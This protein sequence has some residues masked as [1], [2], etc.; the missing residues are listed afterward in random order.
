MLSTVSLIDPT[1]LNPSFSGPDTS[2]MGRPA[3]IITRQD[4]QTSVD[5]FQVLLTNAKAYR[6]QMLA[7]SKAAANFGYALEK[8]AHS[9]A[10]V[11]DPS[12]VCSSLQAAAGLHY[13]MSN[14]HQILSDTVYKQFEIPLLQHLDT[15]KAN[16]EASEAQYERSMRDMSQKIKETEA[17]SMQNGRKRQRDLLQF[18]QALTTLTMQVDELERIKLGYYFGNLESEQANLQLILQ[19]TSTIVRA[20]VDIYERIAQKGLNDLILEPMTTQG[21][22]PYCTYPT[23][24]EFS[25]I[26][27]ILPATPIIP[28]SGPSA[29]ATGTS[30]PQ[31][32]A[33]MSNFYTYHE[34]NPFSTA[35][36]QTNAT[37]RDRHLFGEASS[38]ESKE[39]LMTKAAAL[40]ATAAVT[41]NSVQPSSTESDKIVKE[42][43]AQTQSTVSDAPHSISLNITSDSDAQ[44][45]SSEEGKESNTRPATPEVDVKVLAIRE[46][47]KSAEGDSKGSQESTDSQ[48]TTNPDNNEPTST[49]PSFVVQSSIMETKGQE[50]SV[51]NH[52][53]NLRSGEQHHRHQDKSAEHD[54]EPGS[55]PSEQASSAQSYSAQSYSLRSQSGSRSL[56]MFSS[57]P[58]SPPVRGMIH[59]SQDSEL[60]NNRDF[61]FSYEP[62][63]LLGQR[64]H[65][66]SQLSLSRHGGGMQEFSGFAAMEEEEGGFG[67]TPPTTRQ[68]GGI[69]TS[70][71]SSIASSTSN[72]NIIHEHGLR[73]RSSEGQ[74]SHH[75]SS[76]NLSSLG[77]SGSTGSLSHR[78]STGRIKMDHDGSSAAVFGTSLE[79]PFLQSVKQQ[80]EVADHI[81]ELGRGFDDGMPAFFADD[82]EV[83]VESSTLIHQQRRTQPGSSSSSS[84][85]SSVALGVSGHVIRRENGSDEDQDH[86]ER[87]MKRFYG[88]NQSTESIVR[89]ADGSSKNV[90][91][92]QVN[93]IAV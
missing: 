59:I 83:E 31:P 37:P 54:S 63:E 92:T 46:T 61:S 48:E 74:L 41:A 25:S 67:A 49:E 18:R 90:S 64:S 89:M 19:K 28:T 6:L 93:E 8:I 88:A 75:R 55:C 80:V 69:Q 70:S 38:A 86:Q 72:N 68:Q 77:S 52:G 20:E 11:R 32:E 3:V 84:S 34:A 82:D 62:S 5:M 57:T 43:L 66:A 16:I 81:R 53:V 91:T 15:H 44:K 30:T 56:R 4:Q 60:L 47:S 85:S 50:A 10:S 42:S 24:D 1:T 58:E 36:N 79:E 9:K 17:T 78:R 51:S 35:R 76:S 26:F 14:H 87:T 7:L 45:H 23:T 33:I 39:S 29:S 22:D 40:T 13:L 73:H 65:H 21:P 71:R 27:S 2:R 12:N